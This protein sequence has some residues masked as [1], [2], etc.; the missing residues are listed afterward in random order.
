M[1]YCSLSDPNPGKD[2][3]DFKFKNPT[4]FKVFAFNNADSFY[5]EFFYLS[6]L[7]CE[8]SNIEVKV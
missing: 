5:N 1:A 2:S 4:I 3:F 8:S 7:S 6:F